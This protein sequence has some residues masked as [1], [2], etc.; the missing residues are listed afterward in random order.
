MPCYLLKPVPTLLDSF[1]QITPPSP[2]LE[3]FPEMLDFLANNDN[4][5]K[6]QGRSVCP[7][8]Q[9]EE[10]PNALLS[11]STADRGQRAD[12][13][14]RNPIEKKTSGE[15]FAFLVWKAQMIHDMPEPE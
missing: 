11:L 6:T 12:Q 13:S 2:L 3:E 4:G 15:S 8:A 14:S 5:G 9:T 7:V 1:L 10:P